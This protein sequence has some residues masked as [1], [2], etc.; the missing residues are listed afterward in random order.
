MEA[1][2]KLDKLISKSEEYIEAYKDVLSIDRNN[3]ELTENQDKVLGLLN[4]FKA[5][6][7]GSATN[8]KLW[9]EQLR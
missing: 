9:L 7:I 2:E 5:N 3:P 1:N 8:V 4:V 6:N